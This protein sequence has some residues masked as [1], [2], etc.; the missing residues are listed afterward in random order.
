MTCYEPVICLLI[1]LLYY[2]FEG[3]G[4]ISIL[5]VNIMVKVEKDIEAGRVKEY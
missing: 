3:K 2:N 4:N 5:A 1:R